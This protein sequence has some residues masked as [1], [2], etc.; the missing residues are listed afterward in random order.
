MYD[1]VLHVIHVPSKIRMLWR[2]LPGCL[3]YKRGVH[4]GR[5]E[6]DQIDRIWSIMGV[7]NEQNWEGVTRLP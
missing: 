7:P 5:D 4:A 1:D 3:Y 2:M 6:A